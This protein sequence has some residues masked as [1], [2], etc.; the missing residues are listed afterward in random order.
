M[1]LSVNFTDT[2]SKI[3]IDVDQ[4]NFQK[5]IINSYENTSISIGVVSVTGSEIAQGLL[6]FVIGYLFFSK[7]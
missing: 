1:T 7:S 3:I 2:N 5:G 4:Q 6:E